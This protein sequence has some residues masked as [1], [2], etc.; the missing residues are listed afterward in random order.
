MNDRS[1]DSS[2]EWFKGYEYF[3][4]AVTKYIRKSDRILM[5]GCGNSSNCLVIFRV[6]SAHLFDVG[7]SEEMCLDGFERIVNVDYSERVIEMMKERT[8]ETFPSLEWLAMDF[9]D[10]SALDSGSFD[11]VLDKGS[12]DALWSDGGSQWDP[13][14]TVLADINATISETIRVLQKSGERGGRFISITFGQ[15]HFRLPHLKCSEQWSH[16][17]T[18]QVGLYYIYIFETTQ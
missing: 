5:L 4:E 8:R 10:M 15:P 7:F 16:I 12:L 9:R 13:S 14:E 1:K 18:E 17:G 2:Y 6:R 11:V 3:R